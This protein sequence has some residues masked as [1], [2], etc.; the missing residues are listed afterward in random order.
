M[1][2]KKC[3]RG[4]I[5][6]AA[7]AAGIGLVG[8]TQTS[9]SVPETGTGGFFSGTGGFDGNNFGCP[10]TSSPFGNTGGAT[11]GGF[12][13]QSTLQPQLGATVTPAVAPPAISGGTLRVLRDGHTAVASDPDRDRITVVDLKTAKIKATVT[14][15]SGDEPGRIVEDAAGRVHVSLRRGGAVVTLDPASW[16]S[17]SRRAVCA[18]PRGLAYDAKT[19]LIHV[20]CTDGQLIS[21]PAAGGAAVRTLKLDRDLRDV[22]VDGDRLLVSRFRSA[23]V[24]TLDANGKEVLRLT[25]A[26]F[27]SFEAHSGQ[28]FSPSVAWRMVEMPGGGAAMVHQRGLD[29]VV[30]PQAGGYGTDNPCDAIVHTTITVMKSGATPTVTPALPGMVLPTDLAV[31]PDGKRVAVIA[32]GNATNANQAGMP[33]G[34]P[35]VFVTSTDSVTDDSV[36]CRADGKHGPCLQGALPIAFSQ[37]GGTGGAAST[38]GASGFESSTGGS[39]AGVVVSPGAVVVTGFPSSGGAV[40]TAVGGNGATDGA[41]GTAG[42]GSSVTITSPVDECAPTMSGD[43]PTP[44]G[45]PNIVGE[46]IAV[47]F[48][49]DG[50][51]VV[52]AREPAALFLGSGSKVV[53]STD[54]RADTGHAVFHGNA[55]GF[56]ACASCHAEGAEDGRIW[57]FS[58]EG[59]RRTQSLNGGIAGTEPFHWNGDMKT[60]SQLMDNVFVGRMSGP[61]LV[62]EQLDATLT[63]IDH[64][65]RPPTSPAPDPGAV[66][67]GHALFNDGAKTACATCHAGAK[68]TNN[69]GAD[70]GTGG[71]FQVPSLIGLGARAP[72]MHNGCAKT[73]ADRF[74]IAACGGGDKHGVTSSLG[75]AQIAD[76]I[77]YLET[78]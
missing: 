11:A 66:D 50:M 30:A 72:F 32:T 10:N 59:E 60:F 33:P 28:L 15:S 14:L 39:S 51:V 73:L 53:L 67:R 74:T 20:A 45:V 77:A 22:V 68:F 31:S 65:P 21:L 17:I 4:S 2:K 70:V 26:P 35:R 75:A 46:P 7:A 49:G 19:D 58:C 54:S 8:C 36:G 13:G 5:L 25:P 3:V 24:L 9:A 12:R 16:T 34:L 37:P 1:M 71:M 38:G 23:Q 55:G 64:Q 69:L 44:V 29:D 27:R 47:A 78:L 52:Q 57:N 6:V 40:G 61:K 63:W 41:G 43:I 62:R 56:M 76:L 18:A 48:D 42:V